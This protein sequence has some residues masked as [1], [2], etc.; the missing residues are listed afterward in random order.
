MLTVIKRDV[1]GKELLRWV[2]RP[3]SQTA[4][5]TV[6][7]AV[8]DR[9]DRLELGYTVFERGDIFVETF[10]ATRYYSQFA[11]HDAQRHLKGW[12]FNFNRPARISPQQIE[13]EDLALDVWVNPD[14][15]ATVLDADEFEALRITRAERL[16]CEA[17]LAE[18]LTWAQ[19][20]RAAH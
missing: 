20:V 16:A 1:T 3:L 15:H 18:V 13:V 17:A 19:S 2:G 6:I 7:E 12:Y 11:V 5:A 10:Y 8:F 14:G 9:Y 4:E